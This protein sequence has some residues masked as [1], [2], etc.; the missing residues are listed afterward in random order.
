MGDK[1]KGANEVMRPFSGE[2]DVVACLQKAKLV[3]KLKK[4]GDLASFLPLYLEGDALSLY[5]EMNEEDQLNAA[6][7][8]ERL[9][10]AF[11]D[12]EF[13][14]YGKLGRVKW[15]G[16]QVDV[17]ANE[18]RRLAG[19]AGFTGDSLERVVKL[20]F[21]NGFPDRISLAL[22]QL[23]EIRTI[24]MSDL[25]PKARILAA[26]QSPEVAVVAVKGA[27]S[28]MT[29]ND[30]RFEEQNRSRGIS[31]SFKGRCFR[32][33]GPHM[34]KDCKEPKPPITCFKCG[35]IGHISTYCNQ[36]NEQRGA[37]VPVATPSTE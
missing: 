22:Q 27:G 16:E 7:I 6:R 17:Y 1:F 25:I 10:D 18:V 19:L 21:V 5:L 3:A 26:R 13:A 2:G 14:A 8:E 31:R 29:R 34:I 36:G 4:I 35:M 23:P 32:C 33:N 12:G 37:T 9:K 28:V 15:T 20:T 30:T 24:L 11:T